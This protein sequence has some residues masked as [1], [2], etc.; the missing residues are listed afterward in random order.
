M[1]LWY[2]IEYIYLY[3]DYQ[4][5]YAVVALLEKDLVV[6][7]L[8]QTGYANAQERHTLNKRSTFWL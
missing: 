3:T 5:P 8:A 1:Y 7:D 4:E 6:I 2:K